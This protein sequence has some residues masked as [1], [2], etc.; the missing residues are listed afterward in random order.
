MRRGDDP[1]VHPARLR[2]TDALEL[3]FLQHPQQLGLDVRGELADLVEEDRAAVR[4]LE[5]ALP[6]RHRAGERAA[7]VAEQLAL[8]QRRRQRRAVHAH[9][10]VTAA[11]APA[12]HR[13][14]EQL[15]A[16]AGLAE[17]HDRGVGRRHL[18]H[19]VECD[20]QRRRIADDVFEVV[21]VDA[22]PAR[23][24]RARRRIGFPCA[25]RRAR[26]SARRARWPAPSDRRAAA[27]GCQR[28][29]ARAR[30]RLGLKSRPSARTRDSGCRRPDTFRRGRHLRRRDAPTTSAASGWP[31]RGARPARRKGPRQAAPGGPRWP[32]RSRRDRGRQ[33]PTQNTPG[34]R[35]MRCARAPLPQEGSVMLDCERFASEH[36]VYQPFD[37]ARVGYRLRSAAH[38]ATLGFSAL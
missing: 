7:L 33:S 25:A 32:P 4:E 3:A 12:V 28:R 17:D 13:A 30:R 11:A 23:E 5:A 1:H 15:L 34:S 27:G 31:W 8:D 16:R 2:R 29:A 26:A 21:G 22:R 6:H 38:R 35:P 10:R 19:P 14:R 37:P 20:A 9:E 36:S 24:T 18:E